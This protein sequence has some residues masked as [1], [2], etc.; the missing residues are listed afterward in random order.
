MNLSKIMLVILL[1]CSISVLLLGCSSESEADLSEKQEVSVQRGD[2]AIDITAVG[3]LLFSNKDELTFGM[4][5]TVGEVLVEIGDS[6]KEGQMLVK[7]DNTSVISLQEAVSQKEINVELARINLRDAE[8]NLEEARNPYTE[9]DVAQAE[10]T[11]VNAVVALKVAREAL[12]EAEIPYTES[13]IIQAELAVINAEIARDNAQQNF[14]RAEERYESNWTNPQWI[15][16]YERTQKQLALAEFDLTEAEEA[17]VEMQIGADLLEVE[18]KQKHL[19]VAQANLEEAEDNLSEIQAWIKGDI[20]SQGVELDQMELATVQAALAVTSTQAA[21]DEAIERL[22]MAV[23]VA[24][25]VG[26]V[27]LVNVEADDLVNANQVVIELVDPTKFEAATVV[28]EVDILQVKVGGEAWVEVDALQGMSLPAKVT[29]ISP[30]ATIQSGV[31]NYMVEVEIESNK[32]I[33]KERQETGLEAIQG[34]A[35]GELLERLKQAIKEGQITQE[36]ADAMIERIKKGELPIQRGQIGRQGQR[37][38]PGLGGEQGFGGQQGQ[39][40]TVVPENFQ[41]RE[42]L[43]VTIS[44]LVEARND[45][46]LVPN[47]AI[48]SKGGQKYVQLLSPDGI[49]EEHLVT[50]GLSDW[51]FT[52]IIEGLS[53][54]DKVVITGTTA[55]STSTT[56]EQRPQGGI[57][58]PGIRK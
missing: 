50:T 15:T 42:G 38:L 6:V 51:Q 12:E 26:I 49:T 24:P 9:L 47:S 27:T 2:I 7:L 57:R 21:L 10:A 11:V 3:N 56:S 46:L 35:E 19:A 23:L 32:A 30:T 54:G 16:D 22:E 1:L 39:M 44:I 37:G 20:S 13:D 33:R 25:F 18:Q 40:S 41:L 31:V 52:E 55:T 53:E 43:T 48:T 34:I 17:L 58:I 5:G 14:E 8:E 4:S 28:G 45:V 36:Q 29:Y